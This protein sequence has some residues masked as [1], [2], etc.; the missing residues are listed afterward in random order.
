MNAYGCYLYAHEHSC[1]YLHVVDHPTMI[2]PS[3]FTGPCN[4]II[5]HSLLLTTLIQLSWFTERYT[6][7]QLTTLIKPPWF[8]GH[9]KL[10]I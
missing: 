1:L 8:T 3:W 10:V 7:L 2:Q 5:Y 9:C 6:S 4:S